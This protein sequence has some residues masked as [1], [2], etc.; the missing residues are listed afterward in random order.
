[1]KFLAD[2][3]IP[4]SVIISLTQIGH[5]ILDIKK[6]NLKMKDIEIIRL[7]KLQGR[8]ILTRDKDF[9]VLTQFPKYQ[10]ATIVIRLKIQT[11]QYI[12][13]HLKQLLKNQDERIL[14]SALTIIREDKA[15]SYSY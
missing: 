4:Q 11:P 8:I 1:M 15:D 12:L 14:K 13:K 3:N 9:M 5:D 10:V 6:H 2:V 7:A